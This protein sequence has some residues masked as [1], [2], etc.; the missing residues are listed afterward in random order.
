LHTDSKKPAVP[1]A[2]FR[3]VFGGDGLV[4]I[5]TTCVIAAF[6]AVFIGT[7]SFGQP[8]AA[9]TVERG[10]YAQIAAPTNIIVR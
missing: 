5:K 3:L 2:V 10:P 4:R 1:A 7:T 8:A 9:A 6:A